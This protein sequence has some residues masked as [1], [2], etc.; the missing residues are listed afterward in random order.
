LFDPSK[1]FG[2][3]EDLIS[4]TY[5]LLQL[6]THRTY[7]NS[8]YRGNIFIHE[9]SLCPPLYLY[10][11]LGLGKGVVVYVRGNHSAISVNIPE[12]M[13]PLLEWP[14]NAFETI[15]KDMSAV[16]KVVMEQFRQKYLPR[17][18]P[19]FLKHEPNGKTTFPDYII[20]DYPAY[21]EI[22]TFRD[23]FQDRK[24]DL[25]K[26]SHHLDK[27]NL[28]YGKSEAKRTLNKAV[29]TKAEMVQKV[30][31]NHAYVLIL[32]SEFYP[33]HSNYSIWKGLDLSPFT[34]VFIANRKIG[35]KDY[36][37]EYERVSK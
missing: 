1:E 27:M 11:E 7:P 34:A 25:D 2:I 32:V 20:D 10:E 14:E 16:E 22:T 21:F 5:N 35:S 17:L 18:S 33:L 26:G 3:K 13:A 6:P 9:K 29:N 37:F 28:T 4:A 8:D 15:P 31:K 24:M 23:I 30:P 12:E 19:L 36:E